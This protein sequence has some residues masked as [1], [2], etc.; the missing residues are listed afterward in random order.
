MN[1]YKISCHKTSTFGKV[2]WTYFFIFLLL[3]T[4]KTSGFYMGNKH[5]KWREKD[6]P[7][8][9]GPQECHN[10]AVK[11]VTFLFGLPIPN[12]LLNKPEIWKCQ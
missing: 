12:L 8:A 3:N 10:P 1:I 5:E 7:G 2:E 4:T 6:Q 9:L 11:L